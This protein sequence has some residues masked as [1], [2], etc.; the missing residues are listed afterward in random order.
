MK[1]NVFEK[2]II[3]KINLNEIAS[4]ADIQDYL[5]TKYE[6]KIGTN[7]GANFSD[8][9]HGSD[10]FILNKE[11]ED[12]IINDIT[13][14]YSLCGKLGIYGMLSII[15]VPPKR[16]FY[17]Y[18]ISDKNH[19][20]EKITP[21]TSL[22]SMLRDYYN[23]RI[24]INDNLDEFIRNNYKTTEEKEIEDERNQRKRAE[25]WTRIIAIISILASIF[26]AVFGYITYS[27]EREVY[28]K[29]ESIIDKP[30]P[31][32]IDNLDELENIIKKHIQNIE[33]EQIPRA[34]DGAE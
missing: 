2:E 17:N 7:N 5:N 3:K 1:L 22:N 15:T 24:I 31:I 33:K 16:G 34:M 11:Q 4:I 12:I 26:M 30:L 29:N 8:I 19:L 10:V 25:L 20:I 14:I 21:A 9:K 28:I 32:I 27:N 23:K 18:I 6:I 13:N